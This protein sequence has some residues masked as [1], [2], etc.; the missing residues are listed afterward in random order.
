MR[1]GIRN[2]IGP[3][4]EE[5]ECTHRRLRKRSVGFF[6]SI[7]I[8]ILLVPSGWSKTIHVPGDSVTI[9]AGI[10]GAAD[11]DTV[12]VADGIYTGVGNK[13][14]DFLGKAIVVRSENEPEVTVIECN[15]WGR[16]FFSIKMR[17]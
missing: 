17:V 8:V 13:N 10:D 14:I 16:G 9:Q 11:G 6:I 15:G 4:L 7:G 2:N 3:N 12:L 1:G 5:Q